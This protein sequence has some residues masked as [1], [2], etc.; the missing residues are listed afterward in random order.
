[1]HTVVYSGQELLYIECVARGEGEIQ[2]EGWLIEGTG[3]MSCNHFMEYSQGGPGPPAKQFYRIIGPNARPPPPP[4]ANVHRQTLCHP[5]SVPPTA[6][7]LFVYC[8]LTRKSCAQYFELL[9]IN[10]SKFF[11]RN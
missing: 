9:H 2:R 3:D 8:T 7:Y 4:R 10:S 5:V 6:I 11:I 1:M